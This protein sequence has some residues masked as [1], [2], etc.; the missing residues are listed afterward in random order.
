MKN[1]VLIGNTTALWV[2]KRILNEAPNI[3]VVAEAENDIGLH[4]IKTMVELQP[5]FIILILDIPQLRAFGIVKKLSEMTTS[6]VILISV[7]DDNNYREM[8]H[9]AGVH[10]F[11][12]A[13]EAGKNLLT[14]VTEG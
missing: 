7:I 14:I 6:K 9:Q 11:L 1:I 3:K 13:S 8:A 5:D 12:V 2:I 4:G 10:H